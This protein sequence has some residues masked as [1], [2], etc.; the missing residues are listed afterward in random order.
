MVRPGPRREHDSVRGGRRALH[1][2][3]RD[4]RGVAGAS[5]WAKMRPAPRRE[6]ESERK[7]GQRLGGSPSVSESLASTY[8]RMPDVRP[9]PFFPGAHAVP[10]RYPW[11]VPLVFSRYPLVS[12]IKEYNEIYIC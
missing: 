11:G 1:F 10:M 3:S 8:A 6:R 5:V 12:A 7:C 4:G 9:V 2:F